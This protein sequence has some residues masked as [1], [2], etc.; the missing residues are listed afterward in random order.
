MNFFD[1]ALLVCFVQVLDGNVDTYTAEKRELHPPIITR[2]IRFVPYSNHQRTVCMR[3]EMHGCQW[4]RKH[5]TSPKSEWHL[6]GYFLIK[7]I[8]VAILSL[9]FIFLKN[10]VI[11]KINCNE[12]IKRRRCI[13]SEGVKS[14]LK[15]KLSLHI[16]PFLLN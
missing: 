12:K 5:S 2:R 9:H 15:K 1:N 3:V 4:K 10:E 11:T 7:I 6:L 16:I 13:A 8:H 14:Y